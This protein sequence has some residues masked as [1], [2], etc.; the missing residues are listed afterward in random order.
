MEIDLK[1]NEIQVLLKV[2]KKE[3]LTT[4]E[5]GLHTKILKKIVRKNILQKRLKNC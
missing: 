2:I 1:D 4:Y 5:K 3:N